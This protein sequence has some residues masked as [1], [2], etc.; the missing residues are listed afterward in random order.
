MHAIE[1]LRDQHA[2]RRLGFA[3]DTVSAWMTAA[4]LEVTTERTITPDAGSERIAVSLWLARDPRLA[5]T[6]TPLTTR[7]PQLQGASL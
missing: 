6:R 5:A 1:A 2:H 7:K 4:G 3:S